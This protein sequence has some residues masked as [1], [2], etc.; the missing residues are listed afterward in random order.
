MSGSEPEL[1]ELPALDLDERDEDGPVGRL[2]DLF[3]AP[4]ATEEGGSEEEP[5][6]DI[7]VG[8]LLYT[9]PSPRDA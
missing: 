8:C 4:D 6:L 7:D 1:P 2:E 9:S 3:E 5:P